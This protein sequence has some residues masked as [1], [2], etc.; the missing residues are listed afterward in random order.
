VNS[1]FL[2][3]LVPMTSMHDSFECPCPLDYVDT[4]AGLA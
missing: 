1:D 3:G 2:S 4:K